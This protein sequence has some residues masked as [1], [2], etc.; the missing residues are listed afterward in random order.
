MLEI[1]NVETFDL[2]LP[3]IKKRK[4]KKSQILLYDTGRKFD[5]FMRKIKYRNLGKNDDIPHF[6]ITKSG[7]V[8]QIVDPE[9]ATGGSFD[10]KTNKK[11][12]KI[13]VENL[14]WL[15]RNTLTGVYL[16]WIDD[17]Y[18][19]T[20]FIRSW[21]NYMYWDP[22]TPD[23]L[24]ALADLCLILCVKY[25]MNYE[26]VPSSGFIENAKNIDGIVSKSNFLDI[27]T[28][29]NPSFNFNI[30]QENVKQTEHR[31]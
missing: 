20:P 8:Y 12:I 6:C 26:C 4:H 24:N 29:I 22:Y 14:G 16:N 2:D 15:T 9:Y 30:F 5:H 18:R 31:L 10:P 17:T 19:S 28:D 11:Q 7:K 13:A 1:L 27:Y 25:T 23:Q 21:R 3:Q